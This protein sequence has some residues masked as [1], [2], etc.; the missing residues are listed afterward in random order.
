MAAEFL[1]SRRIKAGISAEKVAL[2]A[3]VQF[4][5]LRAIESG[6]ITAMPSV[7]GRLSNAISDIE[8]ERSQRPPRN[9]KKAPGAQT[10][11]AKIPQPTIKQEKN[12]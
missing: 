12:R 11:E 1:R 6:L 4:A 10:P 9:T 8:A 2:R 3:G 7:V 5:T